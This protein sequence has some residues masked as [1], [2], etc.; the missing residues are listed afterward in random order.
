MYIQKLF[1]LLETLDG[2]VDL[3]VY[4]KL[5]AA[6]NNLLPEQRWCRKHT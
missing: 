5:V 6:I 4:A 3:E 2:G 1:Y